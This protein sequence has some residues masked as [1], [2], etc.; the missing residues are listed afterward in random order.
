VSAHHGTKRQSQSTTSALA[1]VRN[2]KHHAHRVDSVAGNL[3]D[4]RGADELEFNSNDASQLLPVAGV[5]DP[6][7]NEQK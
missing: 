1:A 2:D 7:L 5:V 3:G 4:R 6:T